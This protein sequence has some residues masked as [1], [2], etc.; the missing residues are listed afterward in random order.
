MI[1]KIALVT[2]AGSGIGRAAAI[3]LG[4]E[5]WSVV[6]SGRTLKTLKETAELIEASPTLII[7]SDIRD[8]KSVEN[9]FRSTFDHFGQLNLLFNNAGINKAST[10]LEE[11]SFSDWK[12]VLDTNLTGA[13]LC[14]QQAFKIMK[15][16]A[17]MGGRIINNGSLSAYTPRPFSTAYNTSKHGISGLTKSAAL[18]GRNYN[19]CCG[20]IDIGNAQSK[21]TKRMTDGTIQADGSLKQEPTIDVNE[22]GKAVAY[23][24]CLPL[25][26][27]IPFF[28]IM[29]NKMPFI[30]R[31]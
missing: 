3:E 19:I 28:T 9:L 11:V 8:P 22:V 4:K 5:G 27:N 17:P 15:N 12:E 10:P 25:D 2:G 26:I 20:Q 14:L 31:G 13:F 7:T 23:L 16:Q 21:M 30:G 29:A 18:E 1:K 6:L 24:A